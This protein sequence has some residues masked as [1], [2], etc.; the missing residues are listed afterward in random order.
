MAR[1]NALALDAARGL[2]L[3]ARQVPSPNHDARPPGTVIDLLVVHGISL[4]AGCFRGRAVEALFCNRLDPQAHPDFAPLA[5]LCV[6]A[7]VFVRR[8]GTVIQFVPFTERAWHA[9]VSCWQGRE[10]CNDFSIGVELEG[11][12]RHP[13][14]G[15]QYCRLA[16]LCRLLMAAWPALR[17]ER[18]VGHSD[19][20][21]GRKTDPGPHFDWAHF[22][23]L[24][25]GAEF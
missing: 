6:S 17:P 14:T 8:G 24:L 18:I 10:R 7:H 4:P 21:P 11:S 20:A 22:R 25:A 3:G 13:Y 2:L 5:G 23:A 16:Q 1:V 12:D 15:A 9:G 19:I